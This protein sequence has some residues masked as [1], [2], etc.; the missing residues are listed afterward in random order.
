MSITAFLP[1]RKCRT[2]WR[3]RFTSEVLP[4]LLAREIGCQAHAG[5][6]DKVIR[7]PQ[8]NPRRVSVSRSHQEFSVRAESQR[9]DRFFIHNPENL[10]AARYIPNLRG[11]VLYQTIAMVF[12]GRGQIRSV[13]G[14][15]DR[16][17]PIVVIKSCNG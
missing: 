16:F 12:G 2:G 9:L 4:P 13:R 1:R 5:F 14:K 10:T 7:T 15:C 3:E 8:P 17:H 6:L 11:M